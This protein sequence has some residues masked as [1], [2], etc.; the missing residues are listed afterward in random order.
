MNSNDLL[1][2]ATRALAAHCDGALAQDGVGFNGTDASWGKAMAESE[3]WSPKARFIM[4]NKVL[5][6]YRKQLAT[7]GFDL[8]TI[9]MEQDPMIVAKQETAKLYNARCII[10]FVPC[11]WTKDGALAIRFPYDAALVSAVKESFP[12]NIRRWEPTKREWQVAFSETGILHLDK[13]LKS[14]PQFSL[15]DDAAM[16]IF[17]ANERWAREAATAAAERETEKLRIETNMEL[18][19]STDSTFSPAGLNGTLRPFQAADAA[20]GYTN[21]RMLF[22]H[23]P[24]LG[25]TVM[26]LA[27][28]QQAWNDAKEQGTDFFTVI[29]CP[30]TLKTN[31]RNEILRWIPDSVV[32]LV[33]GTK[34]FE[35][36]RG[37]ID[38]LIVNYDIAHAWTEVIKSMGPDVVIVDESDYI[39]NGKARRTKAVQ[40][41]VDGVPYRFLLSGTPVRSRPVEL[42]SQ[43]QAL[44]RESEFGN[45]RKFVQRYCAAYQGRFGWEF[46]TPEQKRLLELHN[47][48]R[49]KGMY[50]RREKS[51][52]LDEL[53]DL[54][55]ATV[56]VDLTNAREY[57]KAE[58]DF[59]RYLRDSQGDEA[60]L[61]AARAKHLVMISTLRNLAAKGKVEA[62]IEWIIDFLE[63]GNSLVV[64]S[65]HTEVQEALI[66]QFP[67]AAHILASDTSEQRDQAVQDIQ[68]GAKNLIICSL[69]AAG[70]GITLTRASNEL[71]LDMSGWTPRDY[72][73]A[74]ARCH[75]IT[76]HDAVTAW[77]MMADGTIDSVILKLINEKR[78]V[79]NPIIT[80]I[81]FDGPEDDGMSVQQAVIEAYA[82]KAAGRGR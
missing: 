51:E 72:D 17:E 41:L 36:E 28:T 79:V 48:M 9:P 62:A 12:Y 43:F 20:I 65:G 40:E 67:D 23:D 21:K 30:K 58:E 78:G 22:G 56:Y 49:G 68:S 29:V 4:R 77:Y 7:Y 81:E 34:P 1:I 25:K 59:L 66:K 13:W 26:A 15:S 54:Q 42:W 60:A 45:W 14:H 37:D 16:A 33:S 55:R 50:T 11:N 3:H 44:G 53:P 8:D 35:F 52:V 73:Q 27:A 57:A 39:K 38:F 32:R 70:Q 64:F 10:D 6:K 80:G 18:S 46:G 24:G 71:F 19:R 82:A 74:E 69:Q 31:W 63:S 61:R 47:L 2:A 76:Q 75:R 5:P